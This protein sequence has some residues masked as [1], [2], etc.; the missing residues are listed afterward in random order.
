MGFLLQCF[1]YFASHKGT[2]VKKAGEQLLILIQGTH[3]VSDYVLE[4]RA[5]AVGSG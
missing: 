2:E 5:I 4:F 1:L 3:R